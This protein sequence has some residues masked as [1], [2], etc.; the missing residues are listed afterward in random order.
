MNPSILIS[1]IA[2]FVFIVVIQHLLN[3]WWRIIWKHSDFEQLSFLLTFITIMME[4]LC[5]WFINIMIQ[6]NR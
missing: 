4:L 6:I 1:N 3:W 5:G 2:L